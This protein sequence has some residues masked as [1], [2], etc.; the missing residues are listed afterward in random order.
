MLDSQTDWLACSKQIR[1]GLPAYFLHDLAALIG[2][3]PHVLAGILGIKTSARRRWAKYGVL[4]LTESDYIYRT[5]VLMNSALNMFEGDQSAL[6]DWLA[7]PALALG[8][9]TP[10]ELLST[11]VGL[12]MVEALIWRVEHGVVS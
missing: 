2:M 6:L 3:R 8:Q 4:N 7:R 11:F 1:Q 9:K 10:S 5:A 12:S